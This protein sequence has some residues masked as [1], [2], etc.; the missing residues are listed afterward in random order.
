MN[1]TV[2][3][4]GAGF[5]GAVIAREL[6][7]SGHVVRVF[8]SRN[9]VAGNCHTAVDGETGVMV[10]MY[11]PHIFHTSDLP[12]ACRTKVMEQSPLISENSGYETIQIY[13]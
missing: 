13:R 11:G 8:E 6:A 2:A 3:I 1:K 9:H 7:Q 5:S 4:V 12:P 10:H